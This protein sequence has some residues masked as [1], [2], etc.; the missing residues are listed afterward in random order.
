VVKI[1]FIS[2]LSGVYSDIDG[3]G[4]VEAIKMAI[5]DFGGTVLGKKI[6]FVS[7]DHQNKADIAA[8]RAREWFDR[9]GVDLLIGGTN[10]GTGLSMAK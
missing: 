4:G 8:S 2:D 10:S 7:A 3:K 1:G 9:D 5:A 6:E